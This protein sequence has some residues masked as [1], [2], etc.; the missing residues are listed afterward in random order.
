VVRDYLERPGASET[1]QWFRILVLAA[2]LGEIQGIAHDLLDAFRELPQVL[3]A[4]PNPIGLLQNATP[5][6]S[7]IMPNL[8][9]PVKRAG[10]PPR[11]CDE[12]SRQPYAT[13]G[14]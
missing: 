5:R 9:Y 12:K 10:L 6:P 13:A 11:R 2:V 14:I 8:A 4:A 3:Q 7:A 1:A